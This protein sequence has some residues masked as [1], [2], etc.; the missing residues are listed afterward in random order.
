MLSQFQRLGNQTSGYFELSN[1]KVSLNF[2]AIEMLVAWLLPTF[3]KSKNRK[4]L[5]WS[6][7][8][9]DVITS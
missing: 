9:L 2:E 5:D 1:Y 8:E 6:I 3:V 7:I 4:E